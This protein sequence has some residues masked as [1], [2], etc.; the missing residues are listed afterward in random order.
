MDKYLRLWSDLDLW[1]RIN[2]SVQLTLIYI[3]HIEYETIMLVK[4]SLSAIYGPI[5]WNVGC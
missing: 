1:F 3:W 4:L 2:G 5:M